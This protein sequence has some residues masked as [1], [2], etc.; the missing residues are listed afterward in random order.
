MLGTE[1]LEISFSKDGIEKIAEIAWRVNETTE[2]IGARRLHT[3]ME[4]LLEV[5]SYSA[6]DLALSLKESLIIDKPFVE[7]QLN[8]L[9][10]DEDLSRYIL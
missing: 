5:V 4:R 3:V 1:D 8:D 2:N 6:S 7:K 10:E 9:A